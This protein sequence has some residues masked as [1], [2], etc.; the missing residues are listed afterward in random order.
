M[1]AGIPVPAHRELDLL[2]RL[3]KELDAMFVT[4]TSR[5][6]GSEGFTLEGG[7]PV[8]QAAAYREQKENFRHRHTLMNSP[9]NNKAGITYIAHRVPVTCSEGWQSG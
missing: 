1:P 6:G 2:Y 9:L 3:I 8:D 5:V 7:V 4:L